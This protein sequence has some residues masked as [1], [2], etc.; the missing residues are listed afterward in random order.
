[1]DTCCRPFL[2]TVSSAAVNKYLFETL[3]SL[4]LDTY[5]EVE[6]MDHYD[7]SVFEFL[8][9]CPPYGFP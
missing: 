9:S 4:L 8:R 1:M 2:I 3:L 6:L 5:P 7:H